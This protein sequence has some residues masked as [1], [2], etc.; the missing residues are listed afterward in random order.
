MYDASAGVAVRERLRKSARLS[1]GKGGVGGALG[2]EG[3]SPSG[4]LPG[5]GSSR[6]ANT[7]NLRERLAHREQIVESRCTHR[8]N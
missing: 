6:R 2:S 7:I 4:V 3:S 5:D 8:G 1:D